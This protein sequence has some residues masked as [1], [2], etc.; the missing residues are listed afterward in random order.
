MGTQLANVT[1][2]S[3]PQP[4]VARAVRI[5]ALVAAADDQAIRT[6]ADTLEAAAPVNVVGTTNDVALLP[7]ITR[8]LQPR[9]IVLDIDMPRVDV[10]EVATRMKMLAP[11][12]KVLLVSERDDVELG[13]T[14]LDCGADGFI[15]RSALQQ[16]CRARITRMFLAPSPVR[17][18][19]RVSAQLSNTTSKGKGHPKE[20]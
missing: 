7:E 15:C 9:L 5:R 17:R 20:S 19:R 4:P 14:A 2:A 12:A 1:H 16:H 8:A 3:S 18:A 6:L 11:S 13:L 10:F